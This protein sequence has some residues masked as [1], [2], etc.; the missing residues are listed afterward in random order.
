MTKVTRTK[1]TRI[2]SEH[3]MP[4]K[5]KD[6]LLVEYKYDKK[7]LSPIIS[8]LDIENTTVRDEIPF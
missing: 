3:Y 2:D 6:T 7:V 1:K 4:P 5:Y 8:E